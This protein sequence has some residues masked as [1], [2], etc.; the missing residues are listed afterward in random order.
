MGFESGL[1]D[2]TAEEV[3]ER[4]GRELLALGVDY[5]YG[6][7]SPATGFDCSKSC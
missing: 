6:G 1:D 4:D 7:N 2:V 5:R 3:A